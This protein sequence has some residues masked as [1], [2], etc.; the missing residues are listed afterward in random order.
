[1][2]SLTW[3]VAFWVD[4]A[5]LG[6][7]P[8]SP[9]PR[10]QLVRLNHNLQGRIL[11]L[12]NN[13]RGDQRI[14]SP[15]L[16]EKRCLY[17]YLPPAYDAR[18]K[19]PLAIFLHG[20]GQDE[21][22]F[23]QTQ[24]RA[25]DQAIVSGRIPPMI[26]AA[27]DGSRFGRPSILTP[28]TFWANSRAGNFE[29]FVMT[30]VWNFMMTNFAV[31]PDRESHA[32]VGASAGGTA[33]FGL[34]IKH[35]DRVKIAIGFMPLLNLR[36]VDCE[37]RYRSDF[38]PE[39]EGLRQNLRGLETLGRRRLVVLRFSDLFVPLFGRGEQAVAGM[40]S[41]NPL[42]LMERHDLRPGDLDL[43]AAY[44]KLDEFNAAAQV[45]SFAHHARKRG[46]EVT[47]DCD[48]IGRHDLTTGRRF[49][50]P[51]LDWAAARVP[52]TR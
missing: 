21:L 5:G 8:P 16:G 30:D 28:T 38:N 15:A 35:K 40:S 26:V 36:Y 33:A 7:A 31:C 17:V 29:D 45:E 11:D 48:P 50:L 52:N 2:E 14:H 42:E 10:H 3:F 24:A 18:K 1:M 51:A 34:A 27:P 44:G 4:V 13:H 47:V 43:Y 39:C 32:L 25:F 49:L 20:A 41:I 12:T 23:L 19:Y 37:G 9:F 46:I 22:F 6:Q